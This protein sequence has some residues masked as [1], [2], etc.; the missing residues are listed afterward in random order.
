MDFLKINTTSIETIEQSF[1]TIAETL[2]KDYKIKVNDQFYRLLDIEF[3]YSH[4]GKFVDPYIHGNELQKET[5]RWYF[6]ESGID[7]TIGSDGNYGG[8]LIRGIGRLTKEG[9]EG[10]IE[11]E[12]HGPLKVMKEL[13][14]NLHAVNDDLPNEFCLVRMNADKET[15]NNNRFILT[16]NRIGLNLHPN[17]SDGFMNKEYRFIAAF[18]ENGKNKFKD[19]DRIVKAAF[20]KGTIDEIAGREILG[21]NTDFAK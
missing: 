19:K 3:Y 12:I 8:I 7:I 1:K 20:K 9:T 10:T 21:Y 5:G 15:D 16:S 2:L 4:E 11:E 14:T 13:M 17:D 18:T 6:H